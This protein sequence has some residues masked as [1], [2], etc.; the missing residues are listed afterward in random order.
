VP[1]H[2]CG[3]I[4]HASRDAA[5]REEIAGKDEERHRHDL[6]TLDPGE[7]LQRHRVNWH[8]GESEHEDQHR[9][10]KRDRDR[11]TRQHQRDEQG[12]DQAGAWT[13]RDRHISVLRRE[14]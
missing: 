2:G 8:L 11:H 10:A 14:A 7:E 12:E 4:Y 9:Q 13:R 3:E 1:D 6:E 5:V